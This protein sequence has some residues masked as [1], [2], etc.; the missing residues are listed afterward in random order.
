MRPWIRSHL[1]YANVMVTIL[2]FLVL[3]GGSAVALSG[4]NTVFTDDIANDT[5]PAAGGNPAGGLQAADLRPGS[6]ASSEVANGSLNDEDVGQGTFVNFAANIG[7]L[8]ANSCAQD[9]ITGITAQGDHLLLTP[10]D[11]DSSPVLFYRIEYRPNEES[12]NLITC[13]PWNFSVDDGTTH[14]SLLVFD[15]Q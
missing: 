9:D 8:V 2:A 13:N 7:N 3:G 15:A 10:S 1:T 4:S 6:V 5:Q 12:A 14:F 11:A